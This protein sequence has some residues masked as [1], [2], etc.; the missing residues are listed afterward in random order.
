MPPGSYNNMFED[1]EIEAED[2][3]VTEW[4]HVTQQLRKHIRSP[5]SD[6]QSQ[7][8]KD[9]LIAA[10]LDSQDMNSFSAFS[11]TKTSSYA[12]ALCVPRLNVGL[13]KLSLQVAPHL[14]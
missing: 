9:M 13:D 12:S 6:S 2:L 5:F 3:M 1:V 11:D 10:V 7:Y 4:S 14:A 8:K